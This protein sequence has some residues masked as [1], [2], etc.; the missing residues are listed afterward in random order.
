[1]LKVI[2]FVPLTLETVPVPL[3]TV[4]AVIGLVRPLM[5]PLEP[6]F[7]FTVEVLQLFTLPQEMVMVAFAEPVLIRAPLPDLLTEPVEASMVKVVSPEAAEATLP[8]AGPDV[9]TP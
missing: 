8:N 5:A 6:T 1:M 4:K 3:A 2:G 9:P 7:S